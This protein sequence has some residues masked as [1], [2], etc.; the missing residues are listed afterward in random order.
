[1]HEEFN[2]ITDRQTDRHTECLPELLSEPKKMK[3][4]LF[5]NFK[6]TAEI[7][8]NNLEQ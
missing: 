2:I 5:R 4:K 8:G 3:R 1:M 7:I 6:K